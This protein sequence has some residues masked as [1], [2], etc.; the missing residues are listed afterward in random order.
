MNSYCL[1]VSMENF[2]KI[3]FCFES[4]ILLDQIDPPIKLTT[5]S[6][7]LLTALIEYMQKL[8]VY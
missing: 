5:F 4:S 6:F 2:N 8:T 1:K 7:T 3:I